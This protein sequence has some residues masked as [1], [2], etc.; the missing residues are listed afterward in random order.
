MVTSKCAVAAVALLWVASAATA[1]NA[2][3]KANKGR[4]VSELARAGLV[5]GEINPGKANFIVGSEGSDD[6]SWDRLTPGVDVICGFG[7]DDGVEIL[8]GG[9]IFLGGAGNDTVYE[10]YSGM[11]NG[12]GGNDHLGFMY[13]GEFNGDAGDDRVDVVYGGTFNGGAGKDRVDALAGGIFNGGAGNDFVRFL[14]GG[15]FNQD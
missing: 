3:G 6:F 14:V 5:S 4:C 12:G 7:G 8:G 15:T 1:A 11:F 2:G 10:Q 9:D 13:G